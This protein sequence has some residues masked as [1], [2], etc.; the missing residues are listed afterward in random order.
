MQTGK[1]IDLHLEFIHMDLISA[2]NWGKKR[3]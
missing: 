2:V 3:L 1:A